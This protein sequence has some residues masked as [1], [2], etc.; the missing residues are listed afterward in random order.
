MM[1][2]RDGRPL[3]IVRV[4]LGTEEADASRILLY[5]GQFC[6]FLLSH[7]YSRYFSSF[8]LVYFFIQV[9]G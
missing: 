8:S 3:K 6:V 2:V 1:D 7:S 4:T 5:S 9:D